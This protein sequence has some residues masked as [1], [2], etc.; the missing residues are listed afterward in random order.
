[1]PAHGVPLLRHE[2]LLRFEEI[3]AVVRTA[4]TMGISKIRLTGGEPLVRRDIAT[5]VSMLAEIPG[6]TDLAM[7]TNGQRLA[8]CA[9]ALAEAGLQ[10]VNVSLDAMDPEEYACITRGGDVSNVIE[11]IMAARLSGLNPIKLNCVVQDSSEE[12]NARAVAAFGRSEGLEV[13]YIKRMNL[14]SGHFS[15]VIGGTGG[16]CSQCNRLRL[17]CDGLVRPCLF[18]DLGFSVR[19]FGAEA[20][21]R[22]AVVNKPLRGD[23]SNALFS[24]IG[25]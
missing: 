24:M 10:R 25:G 11:G 18:S 4:V 16:N 13:R 7:T 6:I 9:P 19:E 15:Q 21:L 2:D 14:A 8:V 22:M 5:L 17:S 23:T 3:A 12:P 1:M 20:A